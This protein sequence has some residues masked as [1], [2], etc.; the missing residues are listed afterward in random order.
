M[1]SIAHL[2]YGCWGKNL[3]RNFAAMGVL[4]AIVD[5]D[6]Q[7]VASAAS[8]LGTAAASLEKV[9]ADPAIDAISIASPAQMHFTHAMAALSAGKHVFVEKPIA[10]DLSE[11]QQLCVLAKDRGLVLMVGHLLQYHPVYA[12]LRDMVEAGELGRLL[13]VYSN[14]MSLGK[15]RREENVLWSFAPHDISMIIG[16]F[17][18]SPTH[19]TAQGNVAFTPGVAD[20]VT[21]QMQFPGGGSAHFQSCW[22]HP[23]KEHRLTV[24]G[25]KAMAVFEDSLPNWEEKLK[26]YSHEIDR[27]GPV[28]KPN[29]AE[30]ECIVVEETEPLRNECLH[31]VQCL[32]EGREPLTGGEEGLRVLDVLEQAEKALREN[33]RIGEGA[34]RQ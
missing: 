15:F 28:P 16:L 18:A 21:A 14:R 24:I 33:L 9:L 13:Y 17:G 4:K 6:P 30:A 27:S 34:A 32:S 3:A 29:K 12:K 5:P 23:F 22:I 31:F 7:M 20:M 2:G 25:D 1:P 11:A 19:V 8:T 10:L 26:F